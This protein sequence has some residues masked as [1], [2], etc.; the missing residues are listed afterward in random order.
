MTAKDMRLARAKLI[1][2]ARALALN[3]KAT[4]EDHSNADRM[5]AETEVLGANIAR[6]EKAESLFA[7][8]GHEIQN[9]S[10]APGRA[11]TNDA[12]TH[13]R[14]F[15]RI[16]NGN[17]PSLTDADKDVVASV[18]ARDKRVLVAM[19]AGRLGRLSAE[20]QEYHASRFGEIRNAANTTT[21]T[22][23]GFTI[24]PLFEAELLVA[25]KSFGGMRAVARSIQTDTGATLPWPTMDDTSN[26]AS[27][28][29]S[30][31][32]TLS[33]DTDLV[34]AQKSIGAFTYSSGPL[35][36]SLQLL[37][38]SAFDFGSVIEAAMVNRFGRKQNNDFTTGAG[39][40]LP[41]GVVTGA[42]SGTVGAT[43]QTLTVIYDDFVNL[44]HAVDPAYRGGA[45]FMFH[46][47]TLKTIKLLKDTQNRPLFV[48]SISA[49]VPDMIA[50]FPYT[51]NQSMPVM[52]ANAKSILFGNFSNYI[53]RDVLGMQM[54]VLRERFADS[55]QVAW[56]AYMRS[57]GKLISAASPI[58]YY[59]N[60]AT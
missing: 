57:D 13:T 5:L 50:D 46:D 24:A 52:A 10:V 58:K 25:L 51:I 48:P 60:S 40:T 37:Q 43:G 3:P 42:A 2:D 1:E 21:T 47:S 12:E 30:E 56:L 22:A 18:V 27:I 17:G 35:P 26:L 41:F 14:I 6:I 8:L 39:T 15:N 34:F 9:R 53:I 19:A 4:A 29:G 7:S 20:D 36:V 38:D 55:L 59:A 33:P 11:V 31:N 49:G 28:V 44:I 45:R 54:M 16:V 23:G 32:T